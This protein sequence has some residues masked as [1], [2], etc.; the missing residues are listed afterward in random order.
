MNIYRLKNCLVLNI[1]NCHCDPNIPEVD[2]H[3]QVVINIVTNQFRLFLRA[4]D[5]NGVH[6]PLTE[7]TTY[8]EATRL[9]IIKRVWQR[10][11]QNCSEYNRTGVIDM[12][13]ID[14]DIYTVR[15][16]AFI[17]NHYVGDKDARPAK[18]GDVFGDRYK[19]SFQ[20][21]KKIFA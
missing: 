7:I 2:G 9:H 18:L 19:I 14:F 13:D 20:G 4:N 17:L 11:A 15:K 10:A 5:F 6:T 21:S 12:T 1:Y 3:A 8:S 16:A